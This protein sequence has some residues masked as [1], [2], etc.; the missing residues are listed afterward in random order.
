MLGIFELEGV[1]LVDLLG[2]E[3]YRICRRLAT[4]ILPAKR[5]LPIVDS[6]MWKLDGREKEGW[7][8][9]RDLPVLSE[10]IE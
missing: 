7:I 3:A 2:L 8:Y 10:S 4:S 1:L 6:G 9:G 5:G